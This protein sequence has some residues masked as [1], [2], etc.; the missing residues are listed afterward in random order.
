MGLQSSS[1]FLYFFDAFSSL[2]S[3]VHTVVKVG[4][5]QKTSHKFSPRYDFNRKLG[6]LSFYFFFVRLFLCQSITANNK[7]NTLDNH[8]C[9]NKD[10]V[11][12]NN[13]ELPMI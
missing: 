2:Q 10:F 7:Q 12:D 4:F 11:D 1:I 13:D 5:S 3:S 6:V 9:A 8:T